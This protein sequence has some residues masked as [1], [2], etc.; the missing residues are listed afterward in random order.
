LIE[1]QLYLVPIPH[2]LPSLRARSQVHLLYTLKHENILEFRGTWVKS[3]DEIIFITE[4]LGAGS[5]K[6]FIK[7]VK[8][9]RWK[10]QRVCYRYLI[11]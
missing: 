2:L 8:V 9:I 7:R 10:V 4:I 6:S 11:G 5:L 1:F 3:K